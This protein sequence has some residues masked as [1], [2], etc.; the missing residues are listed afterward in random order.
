MIRNSKKPLLPKLTNPMNI[1]AKA[2]TIRFENEQIPD[3]TD[4]NTAIRGISKIDEKFERISDVREKLLSDKTLNSVG[5]KTEFLKF[6]KKMHEGINR[7]IENVSRVVDRR[8][9]EISEVINQPIKQEADSNISNNIREY[10]AKLPS[11]AERM[12]FIKKKIDEGCNMT[13]SSCLGSLGYLAGIDD[14]ETQ[15]ILLKYY[16]EKRFSDLMKVNS[17]FEKIGNSVMKR[18]DILSRF[19]AEIEKPDTLAALESQRARQEAMG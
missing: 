19:R 11:K 14:D 6:A 5:K 2:F 13:A 17:G 8:T 18:L 1:T 3:D 4:L 16:R 15:Q 7:D 12:A 9:S 10:V